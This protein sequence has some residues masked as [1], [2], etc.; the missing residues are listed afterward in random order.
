MATLD[1]PN[2][3]VDEQIFGGYKWSEATNAWFLI[4]QIAPPLGGLADVEIENAE[5]D[6]LITFD[7]VNWVNASG[8][9]ASII[10]SGTFDDARIPDLDA[11]KITDGTFDDARIPDLDASKVTGGTFDGARIPNF[12][13]SKIDSGTF[14]GARIPNLDASKITS[15][16]F[17]DARIP[18]LNASK[19][20]AGT[21]ADARIPNLNAS[22]IT[23]GT[24]NRLRLPGGTSLQTV[25]AVRTGMYSTTQRSLAADVTNLSVSITPTSTAS[26]ILVLLSVGCTGHT[27]AGNG[28]LFCTFRNG[29]QLVNSERFVYHNNA[30]AGT[31]V[32]TAVLD[33]PNTTSTRT[34]TIRMF[35]L[36]GTA[37]LNGIGQNT[38]AF[39]RTTLTA[40]EVR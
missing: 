13:A 19:T 23:A 30:N 28:I 10:N 1:F 37:R 17:A 22:K 35:T 34:Y 14:D 8:L 15:G 4:P 39:G 9:H 2:D 12:D 6:D 5:P 3:P 40:I 27:N 7:G 11:S 24:F 21:F 31:Q 32:D 25:Q 16:T 26:R 38:S 18:N 20:T 29:T 36:A 33:S